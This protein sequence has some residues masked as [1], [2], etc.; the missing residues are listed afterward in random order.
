MLRFG[1]WETICT[2]KNGRYY[3]ALPRSRRRPRPFEDDETVEEDEDR[4]FEPLTFEDVEEPEEVE[5]DVE[6]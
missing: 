4:V 1:G 6:F 2:A 5:E 3:Y